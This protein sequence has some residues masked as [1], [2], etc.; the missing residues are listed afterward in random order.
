MLDTKK[1]SLDS[2]LK[3]NSHNF[4]PVMSAGKDFLSKEPGELVS[5]NADYEIACYSEIGFKI[6]FY[7]H[8]T[9][10]T[11]HHHVRIRRQG[12]LS[13]RCRYIMASLANLTSGISFWWKGISL[14]ELAKWEK[15]FNIK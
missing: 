8:K 9:R 13:K 1:C 6:T 12:D 15:E 14:N 3:S 5:R 7:P 4:K 2:I 10:S 11:G